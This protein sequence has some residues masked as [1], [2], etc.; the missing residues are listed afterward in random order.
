MRSLLY[1]LLH[2]WHTVAVKNF[3]SV[4]GFMA[5]NSTPKELE[6]QTLVLRYDTNIPRH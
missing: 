6:K 2:N 1:F 4:F 3:S 5:I